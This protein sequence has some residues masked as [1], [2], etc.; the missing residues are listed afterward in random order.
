MDQELDNYQRTKNSN[1]IH[2]SLLQVQ[3]LQQQ[4]LPG[5]HGC[6]DGQQSDEIQSCKLCE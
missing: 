6:H 2:W 3:L 5:L 1:D 4:L